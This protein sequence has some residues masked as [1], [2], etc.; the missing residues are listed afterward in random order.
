MLNAVHAKIAECQRQILEAKRSLGLDVDGI[1]DGDAFL[2]KECEEID[3]NEERVESIKAAFI[4]ALV[5]TLA[6]LPI[7]FT[8]ETSSTQLI[9]PLTINFISCALFGVTSRYTIRRDLDNIQLKTVT[10]A[11]FGFVKGKGGLNNE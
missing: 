6:G 9:L 8:Q 3:R 10:S 7:S 4:S 11:A 2:E 1:K 5:G